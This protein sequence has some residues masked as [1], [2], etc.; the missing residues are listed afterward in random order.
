MRSYL[1]NQY[2]EDIVV[3]Q[4]PDEFQDLTRIARDNGACVDRRYRG[5]NKL[6]AFTFQ[7]HEA[8]ARILGCTSLH[9]ILANPKFIH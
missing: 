7:S 5:N 3:Q 6:G 8:Y 9:A 1:F 2:L 4:N